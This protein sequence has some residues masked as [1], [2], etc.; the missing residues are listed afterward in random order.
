MTQASLLSAAHQSHAKSSALVRALAELLEADVPLSHQRFI[1]RLGQTFDLADSIKISAVHEQVTAVAAP[2]ASDDKQAVK[3][4]YQ[5]VRAAIERSARQSFVVTDDNARMRFPQ[6]RAE[7]TLE[8][9]MA[10]EPYLVFYVA[11]QRNMDY[12]IR[13]LHTSTRDA[14]TALSPKLARLAAL[15]AV[16]AEPLSTAVRRSFAAVPRLLRR[17]FDTLQAAYHNSNPEPTVARERWL[18]TLGQLRTEMQ[19]LLLAEMDARLLPT[20]GLIEAMDELDD[21]DD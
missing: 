13:D 12:R 9:A 10:A 20:L 3:E 19:G 16:L 5:R 4:E 17:R 7:M 6:V 2:P 15:D 14:L 21:H 18:L 1:E 8:E 11:Q